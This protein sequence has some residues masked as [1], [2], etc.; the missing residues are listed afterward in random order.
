MRSKKGVELVWRGARE[1]LGGVEGGETKIR[2]HYVK[3][4]LFSTRKHQIPLEILVFLS[5]LAKPRG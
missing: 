4:N 1:E 5:I 2:I 3:K